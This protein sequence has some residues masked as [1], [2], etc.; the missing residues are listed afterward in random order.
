M[1][2]DKLT[3]S[4]SICSV[5]FAGLLYYFSLCEPTL[6]CQDRPWPFNSAVLS[7]T[8]NIIC[9]G[10]SKI[11]GVV[12]ILIIL[13]HLISYI[14]VET[15]KKKWLRAFLRH[16]I[17]QDLGGDQYE[18]RITI[19]REQRGIKFWP[20]YI[21]RSILKRKNFWRRMIALPNPIDK[22]LVPYIRYSYP[23]AYPSTSYF[24]ISKYNDDEPCSVVSLC[25][26]KGTPV[27]VNAPYIQNITLPEKEED[28][29][30]ADKAK[31]ADYMQATSM[32]DYGKLRLIDRRSNHIFASLIQHD[33][34]KDNMI[35]GVIVFDTNSDREDDLSEKLNDVISSY[36]KITQFSLKIIH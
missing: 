28:L 31:I 22:Y 24:S 11:C 25:Y 15:G 20:K 4:L 36:L 3:I 30:T 8:Y 12:F 6:G 32:S 7:E 34:E 5:L 9:K 21:Y 29:P 13:F 14:N 10:K 16:V 17:K 35:W 2:A 33:S 1:K 23:S 26:K 19:F 18:T 27:N